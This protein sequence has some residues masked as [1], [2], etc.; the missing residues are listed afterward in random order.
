MREQC[1]CRKCVGWVRWSPRTVRKHCQLYGFVPVHERDPAAIAR[2]VEE[3]D[4]KADGMHVDEGVFIFEMHTLL[5]IVLILH[6]LFLGLTL[7]KKQ[8]LLIEMKQQAMHH[9]LREKKMI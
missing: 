9:Q 8:V 3:P 5:F 4:V 7:R 6:P 2:P 1:W